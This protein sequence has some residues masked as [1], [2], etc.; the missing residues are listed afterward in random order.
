[1]H[2]GHA[3]HLLRELL[4]GDLIH[5]FVSEPMAKDGVGAKVVLPVG[6]RPVIGGYRRALKH[7]G[8]AEGPV[9]EFA[10]L[11]RYAARPFVQRVSGTDFLLGCQLTKTR[12]P[13]PISRISSSGSQKIIS[14]NALAIDP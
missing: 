14:A 3:G 10:V 4:Q 7:D 2:V 6:T 13:Q 12:V 1:M 9:S 8:A 5:R 11:G